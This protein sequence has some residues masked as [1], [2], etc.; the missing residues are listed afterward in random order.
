MIRDIISFY[1]HIEPF[2]GYILPSSH[3]SS[4]RNLNENRLNGNIPDSITNLTEL[5]Y[6]YGL[7]RCYI[8]IKKI[9]K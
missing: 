9:I 4:S 8:F 1:L 3:L 2:I 7:Y 6:V 5:N